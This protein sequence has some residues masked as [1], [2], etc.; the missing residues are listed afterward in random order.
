MSTS[1][2]AAAFGQARRLVQRDLPCF[3]CRTDKTPATPHGFKDATRDPTVIES[4]WRAWPGSLV[5]I[6]TGEASGFDVLD[7][8][9]RDNGSN[10]F[11]EHKADLLPSRAH[12]TRNIFF[13]HAAGLRCSTNKIAHGVD[14]RADGGYVIWWPSVG[15]PVLSDAPVA[16]WPG[17]L[18]ALLQPTNRPASRRLVVPDR[19]IIHRL[20]RLVAAAA[21][22]ERNAITFW[23]ACRGGEMV[24]SGL[25]S[26]ECISRLVTEASM[27]SGL[28]PAEAF[29]TVRSGIR[30]TAGAGNV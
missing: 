9:T 25:V 24:G 11:S 23:A 15:L 26:A 13:A 30:T 19:Y 20:L 17:W 10:W 29:R 22:G 27:A 16:L 4:L 3:P 2:I 21:E 7:I 8:D 14:V 1:E 28:S 6:P 12:R 5:G 18:L